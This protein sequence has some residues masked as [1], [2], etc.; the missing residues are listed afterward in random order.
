MRRAPLQ[1]QLPWHLAVP[2][3]SRISRHQPSWSGDS[4]LLSSSSEQGFLIALLNLLSFIFHYVPLSQHLCWAD[5]GDV[6][7]PANCISSLTLSP[8]LYNLY[9]KVVETFFSPVSPLPCL[10]W[11]AL[12]LFSTPRFITCS[13]SFYQLCTFV[14]LPESDAWFVTHLY[15]SSGWRRNMV[16]RKDH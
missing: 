5:K 16:K 6:G 7:S 1:T 12:E 10:H 15:E 4:S 2:W 14:V 9:I 8:P 3:V 11:V 13:L